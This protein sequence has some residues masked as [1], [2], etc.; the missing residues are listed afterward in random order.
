MTRREGW[1]LLALFVVVAGVW[2]G[3]LFNDLHLIAL[4]CIFFL[5]LALL[6]DRQQKRMVKHD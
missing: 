1:V 5:T 6:W 2:V 3:M 4:W